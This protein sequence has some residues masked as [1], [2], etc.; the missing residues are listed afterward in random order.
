MSDPCCE[1]KVRYSTYDTAIAAA[2]RCLDARFKPKMMQAYRCDNCRG[3]HLT[4]HPHRDQLKRFPALEAK[5]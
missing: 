5:Q 2:V 3:W 4:S 1:R